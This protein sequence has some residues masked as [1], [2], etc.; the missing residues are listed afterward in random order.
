MTLSAESVRRIREAYVQ[1]VHGSVSPAQFAA[2]FDLPPEAERDGVTGAAATAL[3]YLSQGLPGFRGNLSEWSY[4]QSFYS[5]APDQVLCRLWW[6]RFV[7]ELVNPAHAPRQ[8]I[9]RVHWTDDPGEQREAI[10]EAA[11]AAFPLARKSD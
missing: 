6:P 10:L 3:R 4:Q 5:D 11:C 8:T 9:E 7:A 1:A 2:M